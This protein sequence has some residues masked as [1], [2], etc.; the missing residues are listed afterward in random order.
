[1]NWSEAIVRKLCLP[2]CHFKW[3]KAH[4]SCFLIPISWRRWSL[5]S[6]FRIQNQGQR[7]WGSLPKMTL[8]ARIFSF[9]DFYKNIPFSPQILEILAWGLSVGQS[10]WQRLSLSS[11]CTAGPQSA[12]ANLPPPPVRLCPP[13]SFIA[14]SITHFLIP[15][16]LP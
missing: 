7:S 14:S 12:L 5:T 13:L 11:E 1:M 16:L 2:L 10:I 8:P 6:S 9:L 4:T 15:P 3:F